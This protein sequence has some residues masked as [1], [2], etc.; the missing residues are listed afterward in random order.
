MT[1]NLI[2]LNGRINDLSDDLSVSSSDNQS[3][4]SCFVFVLILLD[5]SPSCV[6]VSLS[7]SSSSVLD[8]ISL[9]VSLSLY[10]LHECHNLIYLIINFL[11]RISLIFNSKVGDIFFP[12]T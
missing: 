9:V 2:T 10:N 1:E 4:F 3:V 8:L 12:F 7:F 5:K 6:V 11:P